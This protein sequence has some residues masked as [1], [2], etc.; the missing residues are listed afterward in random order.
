LGAAVAI[1]ANDHGSIRAFQ[2]DRSLGRRYES[3]FSLPSRSSKTRLAQ[4]PARGSVVVVVVIVSF[5]VPPNRHR[6]IFF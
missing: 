3:T 5:V 1:A 4:Q 6:E 2:L